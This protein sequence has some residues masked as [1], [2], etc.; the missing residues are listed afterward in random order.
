MK[1]V[2]R[3]LAIALMATFSVSIVNAKQFVAAAHAQPKQP[4]KKTSF[5]GKAIKGTAIVSAVAVAGLIAF[6]M[7]NKTQNLSELKEQLKAAGISSLKQLAKLGQKIQATDFYNKMTTK[8]GQAFTWA[9]EN[10]KTGLEYL[11][12]TKA[13]NYVTSKD[14]QTIVNNIIKVLGNTPSKVKELWKNMF[15]KNQEKTEENAS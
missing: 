6:I 1:T 11:K 7:I 10:G 3:A 13:Y 9:K 15:S 8:S 12:N 14:Y 5:A 4:A 2:T